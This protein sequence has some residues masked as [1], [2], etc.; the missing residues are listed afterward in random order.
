MIFIF[1]YQQIS[2]NGKLIDVPYRGSYHVDRTLDH[3]IVSGPFSEDTNST[4][5]LITSS[6]SPHFFLACGIQYSYCS[7]TVSNWLQS[8]TKGLLGT[9]DQDQYNEFLTPNDVVSYF[10]N[11]NSY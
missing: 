3:I 4:S 5:P 2:V 7:V 1:V 10:P 8:H 6:G 9:L 11:F